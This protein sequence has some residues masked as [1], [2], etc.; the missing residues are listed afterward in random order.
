MDLLIIKKI[1][2]DGPKTVADD[3]EVS[4]EGTC[5]PTGGADHRPFPQ[6][7]RSEE[8]EPEGTQ[9]QLPKRTRRSSTPPGID[10]LEVSQQTS[11]VLIMPENAAIRPRLM[12][13]VAREKRHPLMEGWPA[14]C[15]G[16][17]RPRIDVILGQVPRV[18]GCQAAF[19]VGTPLERLPALGTLADKA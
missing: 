2:L 5:S 9:N 15:W 12:D 4:Q 18:Y 3:L 7:G 13:A 14:N 19:V 17:L 1:W 6:T 10:T 8:A 11:I 16:H